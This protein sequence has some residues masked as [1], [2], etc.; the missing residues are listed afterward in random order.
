MMFEAGKNNFRGFILLIPFWYLAQVWDISFS[1]ET[2]CKVAHTVTAGL[3]HIPL[4][5]HPSLL[6]KSW[7]NDQEHHF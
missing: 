2:T 5:A 4:L 3:S 6:R 1:I 7:V